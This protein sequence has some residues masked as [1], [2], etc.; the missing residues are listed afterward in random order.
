MK[1][2]QGLNKDHYWED[3]TGHRFSC[4]TMC[5]YPDHCPFYEG[6]VIGDCFIKCGSKAFEERPCY[7]AVRKLLDD[8]PPYRTDERVPAVDKVDFSP[9]DDI[10]TECVLKIEIK[11]AHANLDTH[12]YSA[13]HSRY[14]NQTGYTCFGLTP[15]QGLFIGKEI[16]RHAVAIMRQRDERR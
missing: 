2:S 6:D 4:F 5:H 16:A 12:A 13:H 14:A 8:D 7:E 1:V 3:S 9:L 15:E 10:I 11:D